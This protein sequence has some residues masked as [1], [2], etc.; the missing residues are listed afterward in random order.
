ME[1]IANYA[2]KEYKFNLVSTYRDR[3]HSIKQ[4]KT[5]QVY[6]LCVSDIDLVKKIEELE[7]QIKKLEEKEYS[8]GHIIQG[9]KEKDEKES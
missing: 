4:D 2:T 7:K 6:Y 1:I 5:D 3:V 8:G 9:W